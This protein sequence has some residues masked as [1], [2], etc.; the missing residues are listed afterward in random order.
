MVAA[1]I[2]F[3]LVW[4]IFVFLIASAV[5]IYFTRP[6]FIEKLKVGAEKTNVDS[7]IGE[8]GIVTEDIRPYETGLVKVLG[9]VWTAKSV[10]NQLIAR[11]S[12]VRIIKIEGVKVI[13]ESLEK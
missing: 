3:S 6:F 11:D 4:Q 1:I 9:Q 13:V 7:L 10:N 2:G 12:K 5:L 8:M